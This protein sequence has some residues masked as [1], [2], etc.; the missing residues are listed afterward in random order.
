MEVCK[1]PLMIETLIDA[2]PK[3]DEEKERSQKAKKEANLCDSHRC[4]VTL[5]ITM[6]KIGW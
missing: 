4:R 3:H 6:V 5:I 1:V 2:K